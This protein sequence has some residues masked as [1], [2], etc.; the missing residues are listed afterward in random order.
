MGWGLAAADN[1]EMVDP[2]FFKGDCTCADHCKEV[3]RKMRKKDFGYDTRL[4]FQITDPFGKP[5]AYTSDHS[6][7]RLKWSYY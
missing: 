3:A 1:Y 5:W 6:G 2:H 4:C 7:W